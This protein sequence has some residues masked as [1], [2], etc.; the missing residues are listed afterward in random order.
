MAKR[1]TISKKLRFEVFKRDSFTC[2][3]CG[4][5]APDTILEV[6]HINP[7]ANGGDNDILNLITS[8]MD[9]NRGKGAKTLSD[10]SVLEKQK[11]QLAELNEK[12]LQ[13]EMMIEWKQE[14]KDIN[15]S[16]VN[17]IEDMFF[18][19]TNRELTEQGRCDLG[20]WIKKYGFQDIWDAAE[21]SRGQYFVSEKSG[22]V[23][24][25][26][27]GKAFK[28]IPRIAHNRQLSE[29]KPYLKDLYYIRGIVR[30]RMRCNE[31]QCL[32][33]L[34]YACTHGAD[35]ETLKHLAKT[36]RNWSELKNEVWE[37]M[38]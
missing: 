26:S 12:R 22:E 36:V 24:P 10:N 34:E 17:S 5:Q 27:A 7:V 9:C 14:L 4:R 30:N 18:K 38:G 31:A 35:I 19:G 13:L 16:A 28:Y 32:Q 8:C 15:D 1:K 33:M 11:A 6:D 37:A 2:Q 20:K 23:T 29:E 3:Y 21:I 25:E